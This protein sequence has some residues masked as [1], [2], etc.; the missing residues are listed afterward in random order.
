M[1]TVLIDREPVELYKILKFEGLANSGA[2]AKLM[3]AD[4]LVSVNSAVET[5][6]R[7][8]MLS[9]DV[10]CVDGIELK[11]ELDTNKAADHASDEDSNRI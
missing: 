7:R 11:L 3:I 5:R 6:K 1:R 10:L 4:G 2:E 9:G 8:K